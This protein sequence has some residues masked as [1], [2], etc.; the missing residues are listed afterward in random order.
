[1]FRDEGFITFRCSARQPRVLVRVDVLQEFA[2]VRK[3]QCGA[4]GTLV[5][6]WFTQLH[7]FCGPADFFYAS[8]PAHLAHL[9]A[10]A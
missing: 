5:I 3:N 10:G 7:I 1:M 9:S 4:L 8:E 6:I 2:L